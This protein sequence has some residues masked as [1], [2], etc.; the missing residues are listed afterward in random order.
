MS[1]N[2]VFVQSANLNELALAPLLNSP[3]MS[4]QVISEA[5]Q[6]TGKRQKQFVA[7]RYLLAELLNDYFAIPSLPNIIIGHNNRPKFEKNNL[8]DFNISHSGDFIAVAICTQ[9]NIGI[10]IEQ[11]RPRKNYLAIAK[12]FFSAPETDWLN[13]QPDSLSAFWQLWTLRESALKLYAKGVWQMKELQLNM[14]QQQITAKFATDFYYHHQ[15]IE[16]IFL[17]VCCNHSI[18]SIAINQ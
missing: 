8:P 18:D 6:L 3:L 5:S 12:Q 4:Q 9:G 17:S 7:C 13:R 14:I 11:K 16:Q 15:Q 10:D 1:Q 2:C